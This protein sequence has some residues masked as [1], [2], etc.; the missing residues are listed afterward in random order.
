[1]SSSFTGSSGSI[2]PVP[3]E[4]EEAVREVAPLW[5]DL[6]EE[7]VDVITSNSRAASVARSL[8]S[9]LDHRGALDPKRSDRD[10]DQ[11][12]QR[13]YREFARAEK[14]LLKSLRSI[15]ESILGRTVE[16]RSKKEMVRYAF[17]DLVVEEELDSS[18]SDQGGEE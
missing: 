9:L 15:A 4:Y 3:P 12:E 13:A 11:K 18:S 16:Y 10:L 2:S 1:L 8:R 7:E 14:E 17:S 5:L 6:T